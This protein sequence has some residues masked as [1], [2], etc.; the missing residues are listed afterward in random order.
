[1]CFLVRYGI[2]TSIYKTLKHKKGKNMS[3]F[4]AL[5]PVPNIWI[6]T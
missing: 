6:R 1:M 3:I 4:L 2:G 5:D